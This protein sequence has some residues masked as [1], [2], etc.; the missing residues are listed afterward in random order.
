MKK[1]YPY[2]KKYRTLSVNDDISSL[3]GYILFKNGTIQQQYNLSLLDFINYNFNNLN[4]Y[5]FFL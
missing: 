3:D 5:Y 2:P 4:D 1:Y